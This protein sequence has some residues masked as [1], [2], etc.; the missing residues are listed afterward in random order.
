MKLDRLVSIITVLLR[1]NRISARELSEMFEVSV[2]T[3][4]RDI[5][6]INMAGIPIVTYQGSGGGIG[7]AEGYK[8]DKSVLTGDEMASLITSLRGVAS[9]LVDPKLGILLDK[10]RN[11]IP[12]SQLEAVNLKTSQIYIDMSPW[13]GNSRLKS[14][15]ELLRR[16]IEQQREVSFAYIDSD[17]RRTERIVQPYTLVLKGQGW[18]LHGW[19]KLRNAFRLFKIIRARDLQQL[20]STFT[21]MESTGA[22]PTPDSDSGYDR[23]NAADLLLVFD[24]SAENIV[25]E[26][27][28]DGDIEYLDGKL[29][30]RACFPENNWLYGFLLS[31][32]PA[33]EIVEPKHIRQMVADMA[34]AV[35]QKYTNT[36]QFSSTDIPPMSPLSPA[37]EI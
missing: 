21:R 34:L 16:A 11:T 18:Y 26:W 29:F 14:S 25:L 19:C 8:L 15:L 3:I 36:I 35:Y 4:L 7:I 12:Q 17:G 10:I 27:F 5:E 13:G 23:R 33:L 20:D 37:S 32:G 1:R 6:A 22:L 2:R 31:F 28:G 30:V 9:T 24:N